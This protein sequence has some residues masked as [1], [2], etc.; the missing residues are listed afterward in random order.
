MPEQES[1]ASG[2]APY[3][4]LIWNDETT[5]MEF[6]VF[7]L[8]TVFDRSHEDAVR[9]MLDAHHKGVGVV[10]VYDR[11]EEAAS[12]VGEAAALVCEN[13]H[14]LKL[15][16]A[17]GNAATA[18]SLPRPA[19][20]GI[21]TA[22][23]RQV[24][25]D[26]AAMHVGLIDGRTLSVPLDWFPELIGAP[27]DQRQRC[28]LA[29]QGREL[30]WEFG[31]L[32]SVSGL[33]AGRAGQAA[34]RPPPWRSVAACREALAAS[35]RQETPL[36]WAAAEADLGHALFAAHGGPPEPDAALV[37][38]AVAAYRA[39]LEECTRERAPL[40]WARIQR[41]LG[42]A[43]H[44][45]GGHGNDPDTIEAAVL[46]LRAALA[47]KT[48]L[49]L[50]ERVHAHHCLG[51]ALNDL[52]NR[53]ADPV[54]LDEAVAAFGAT[55]DATTR[56]RLPF[57]WAVSLGF[58]GATL[59][60]VAELRRDPAAAERAVTQLGLALEVMREHGRQQPA[61]H[62]PVAE[63][64]AQQLARAHALLDELGRR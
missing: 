57:D 39:A 1:G 54:R 4:V 42:L 12:K 51:H 21:D 15:T 13:R 8:Q 24:R 11:I 3:S 29:D 48:R 23:A 35:S 9:I 60:R 32:V 61:A 18:A 43:L 38:E 41:A 31:L 36:A 46:A 33:L 45:L 25:F 22:R 5:P 59:A 55:L 27:A 19:E 62:P 44:V 6:V 28:A 17:Q 58:Q 30:S 14:V 47:E 56:E 49:P 26:D 7:L 37:A 50:P 10:A 53:E 52:G 2:T 20:T 34:I 63:L 16:C 64:F 40:D